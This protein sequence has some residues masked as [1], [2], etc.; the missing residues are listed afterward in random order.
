[1]HCKLNTFVENTKNVTI[2][3]DIHLSYTE[4]IW[5]IFTAGKKF[6]LLEIR[7]ENTLSTKF[8]LYNFFSKEYAWKDLALEEQWRVGVSYCND[9]RALFHRYA[10]GSVPTIAELTAVDLP[11]GQK[12][13]H[14]ENFQPLEFGTEYVKG[15]KDDREI[16]VALD[17]GEILTQVADF[18][19]ADV[20]NMPLLPLTYLPDTDNF[21]SVKQYIQKFLGD[22]PEGSIEYLEHNNNIFLSY[23][24]KRE[25]KLQV[26]LVCISTEGNIWLNEKVDE[27][28]KMSGGIFF[29]W[30]DHLVFVQGK[31][32]LKAIKLKGE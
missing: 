10:M 6:L 22:N 30:N 17:S 27:S 8:D 28:G 2:K 23:H 21:V 12:M 32:E 3:P 20:M 25:D 7:D 29:I 18:S 4:N 5:N 19:E 15:I 9:K 11:T 31:H 24:R 14:I 26:K 1:M 16:F 13:W